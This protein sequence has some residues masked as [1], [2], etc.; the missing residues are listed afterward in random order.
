MDEINEPQ[1]VQEL[2]GKGQHPAHATH[3]TCFNPEQAELGEER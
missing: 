2:G 1:A 3:A